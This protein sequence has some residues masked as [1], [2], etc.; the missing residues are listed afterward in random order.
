MDCW[1]WKGMIMISGLMVM[2]AGLAGF[3]NVVDVNEHFVQF[4]H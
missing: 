1:G 2:N 3:V 4:K